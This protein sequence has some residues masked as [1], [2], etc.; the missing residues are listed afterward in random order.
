MLPTRYENVTNS[1]DTTGTTST[2]Y[3]RLPAGSNPITSQT[4]GSNYYYYLTDLH[5]S[6]VKMTDASGNVV[7]TYD[8]EPYGQQISSTGTTPNAIRYAN[9][10]FDTSTNLYKYG[11]RYYNPSDA[12]WTQLDPSG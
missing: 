2:Y 7:N 9:G 4:I 10:Y 1:A 12:R 3:T 5:G 6:T 8:Y 11:A